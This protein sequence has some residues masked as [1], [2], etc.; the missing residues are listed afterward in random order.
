[1]MTKFAT[2][3]LTAAVFAIGAMTATAPAQ[4]DEV[5]ASGTFE[6]RSDHRTDGEVSIIKTDSGYQV[7]L[8]DDFSLD[9]A[10]D[11]TLAFGKDGFA[12]EAEFTVLKS[13]DG[14]QVYDLP[15]GLDPTAY[16]EF[17]V[18]CSEYA[19]PLGFADLK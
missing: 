3:L 19:V 1:M 5:I 11:P 14:Y 18:W 17:Y 6:G 9:G 4:A 8:S 12:S 7:V 15:E 10:P 2:S 16:D 13:N